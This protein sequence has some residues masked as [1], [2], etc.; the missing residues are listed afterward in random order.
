MMLITM[1]DV[2]YNDDEYED[3]GKVREMNIGQGDEEN[4]DR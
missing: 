2:A 3:I 4:E 1:I